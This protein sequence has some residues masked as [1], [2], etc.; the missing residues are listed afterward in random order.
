MSE[1]R[2]AV[3]EYLKAS[4]RGHPN[5]GRAVAYKFHQKE[6]SQFIFGDGSIKIGTLEEYRNHEKS[7]IKDQ[8]DGVEVID[9]DDV[10]SQDIHPESYARQ[11][12]NGAG[13]M[14]FK[15]V[16]IVASKQNFYVYCFSYSCDID[17]LNS[18]LDEAP[19]DAVAQ[20]Q[21]IFQ[22]A[23]IVCEYHPILRGSR[24]LC[25]PIIYREKFVGASE[26]RSEPLRTAFEKLSY[27]SPNQEGR[28]VFFPPS[29]VVQPIGPWA[30]P[31]LKKLFVPYSLPDPSS[32]A[33]E[34][35]A[36]AE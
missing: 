13:R 30:H 28:I 34:H 17:T 14:R 32:Q 33:P 2:L 31:R 36:N 35:P 27:Y 20:C 21:D 1:W 29:G 6:H 25:L 23:D 24:Y 16:R 22:L 8:W 3:P 11:I 12:F 7:T 26:P 9:L 10:R 18:F 15:N 4:L 19:Y 5:L